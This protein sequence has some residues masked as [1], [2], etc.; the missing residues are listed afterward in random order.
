MAEVGNI[1]VKWGGKEYTITDLQST[2]TVLQF[3]NLIYAE[4]CVLPERQK[5]LGLKCSGKQLT[6]DVLLSELSLKP[7]M[8]IMMI[9]TREED[10][11]G[12]ME[13]PSMSVD[14]IND[15]DIED[16]E[17]AIQDR[18]E[19]LAKIE[20]RIKTYDFRVLNEPRPDKLLLVLDIDYTLF[21]HRSVAETGLELMRPHLHEFLTSAYTD[22]D[23]VIWSATS[24][25]WIEAKMKE[26]G[27][28][29]NANYRLCM[30]L[31]DLAM[32]TVDT[33]TYG[34]IQVK[35]LGVLWG[36]FPQWDR[37]NTVMVDDLRRNFIMNP[38]N[39]L[40][41][42]P[43][44]NAHSS[45]STDHELQHLADY[46]KHIAQQRDFTDV[47]HKHW[48]RYR[49]KKSSVKRRHDDNPDAD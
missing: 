6:D 14:V 12:V 19:Y 31:D 33:P 4:T 1:I 18:E 27:V 43:F 11:A 30:M 10:L 38:Q 40:K 32:I 13:P 22:Y 23:I 46:L 3:K 37:T 15:F 29:S 16:D 21:D 39:G 24:K 35:P 26:L 25:K 44:K 9:G 49:N 34:V 36:K 47:K 7:G 48:E 8:K 41:I 20:K 2:S 28:T 42:R 17:I 45:R 5:L